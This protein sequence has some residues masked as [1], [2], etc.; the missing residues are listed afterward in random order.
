[1]GV[2]ARI[3]NSLL[4]PIL[5]TIDSLSESVSLASEFASSVFR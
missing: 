3:S 1:M 4:D 5:T 2:D